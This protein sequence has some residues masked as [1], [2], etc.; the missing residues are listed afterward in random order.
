MPGTMVSGSIAYTV[1]AIASQWAAGTDPDDATRF[2]LAV[3]KIGI[4]RAK[5]QSLAYRITQDDLYD[6]NRIVWEGG[7]NVTKSDLTGE[8]QSEEERSA[9][10]E[11]KTFLRLS[12]QRMARCEQ[13][14]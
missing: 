14:T 7:S 8:R 13:T 12:A 4:R 1:A 2:V 11:A 10:D 3:S 9:L 5:P 6:T